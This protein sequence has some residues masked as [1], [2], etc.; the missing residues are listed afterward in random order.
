MEVAITLDGQPA[1][2]AGRLFAYGTVWSMT[3]GDTATMQAVDF[4]WP[5]IQPVIATGDHFRS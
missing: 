5:T 2:L 3:D 4:S 1:K